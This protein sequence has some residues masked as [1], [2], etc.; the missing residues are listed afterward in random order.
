MDALSEPLLAGRFRLEREVGRGGAGIVYR[1]SDA[2]SKLDV[3]IKIIA[4]IGGVDAVEHSRFTREG[5]LLA[6]LDHPGIVRVVAFGAL[7]AQYTDKLGRRLEEGA[8]YIAMEWLE[9]ED[10]Q[11]RQRRAP[12]GLPDALEVGRQVAAALAAAHQAGIVHRDIKPSNIFLIGAGAVSDPP[13]SGVT[14]H[15]PAGAA[16][17]RTKLVDF[18]V[19]ATNDVRLTRTGAVVGTPA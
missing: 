16:D 14:T 4:S 12:L 5:Q 11:A 1:A 13:T 18:G 17:I 3:A 6:E 7:D 10:L 15:R 8:P 2:L 9:G 19:A